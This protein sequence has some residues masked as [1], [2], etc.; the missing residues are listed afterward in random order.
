MWP[1]PPLALGPTPNAQQGGEA[2][3]EALLARHAGSPWYEAARPVM[4]SWTERL[5]AATDAAEMEQMM[6][7]VLPFYVAEPD[8]PEATA[9]LAKMSAAMK[10]NL[11][12]GHAWEAGL[13]QSVDLRPLLGRI[14]CPTLIVAGEL[15]FICGP[16][17][18]QPIAAAITGAQLVMLPGCGHIPSIETP[19]QYRHTVTE[20]LRG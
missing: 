14:T 4:D 7:T 19:Q 17:Q 18:A 6:A 12:A 5:L 8:K 16:A 9:R 1:W 10:A 11:A 13:Y 3:A 15:D 2:E 20:F